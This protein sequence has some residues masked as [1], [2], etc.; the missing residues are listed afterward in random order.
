[1]AAGG[2]P[3]RPPGAAHLAALRL[4]V[5]RADKHPVTFCDMLTKVACEVRLRVG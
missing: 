5:S 4:A 1:V 2:G 3:R